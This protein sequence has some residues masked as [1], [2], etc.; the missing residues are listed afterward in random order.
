MSDIA[1]ALRATA[2]FTPGAVRDRLGA[3]GLSVSRDS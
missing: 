2:Y 1:V 3:R